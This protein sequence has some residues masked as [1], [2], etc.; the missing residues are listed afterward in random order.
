MSDRFLSM[1]SSVLLLS[2]PLLYI[3]RTGDQRPL[4]GRWLLA[5]V[6]AVAIVP[7][8]AWYRAWHLDLASPA[9]ELAMATTVPLAQLGVL[10]L[11]LSAFKY[12]VGRPPA[13]F[14][15]QRERQDNIDTLM[16]GFILFVIGVGG[17][18]VYTRLR[19]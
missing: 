16:H 7:A 5:V 6:A 8:A 19:H 2:V 9:K 11:S 4:R 3:L 17:M 18:F 12:F 15:F 1:A 10:V 14:T 13:R